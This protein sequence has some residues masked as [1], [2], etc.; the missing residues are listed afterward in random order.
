MALPRPAQR[1]VFRPA[2]RVPWA[3]KIFAGLV[4]LLMLATVTAFLLVVLP[5]RVADLGRNE[6]QELAA[7]RR[8]ASSVSRSLITLWG[9]L[10]TQAS[11]T[12]SDDRLSQ[13]LALAQSTEKATEDALAHVQA[14]QAYL[15]QADGVPFQLHHPAFVLAD[16]GALLHLE[17]TLQAALKLAHG[18]SL[19]LT[20]AQRTQA[21]AG[22]IRDQLNPTL[23]A[24]AWTAAARSASDVQA[25]LK[26][27]ADAV[28]NPEALVDPLW[29]KWIDAMASYAFTAQQ[30][31]LASASG[32]TSAAQGLARSLATA[33]DQMATTAAAARQGLPSWHQEKV[34]PLLSTLAKELAA[35]GA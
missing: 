17:N 6:A 7:S 32:Q 15:L 2:R 25:D 19:Q 8:G 20:L 35:S 5:S 10:G 9:E 22:A 21:D 18:A 13:D 29:A 1:P 31:A 11:F 12:L 14:A 26:L 34:Q 33:G 3:T 4:L 16:R 28:L 24:R 27:Q 30:Y 23:R